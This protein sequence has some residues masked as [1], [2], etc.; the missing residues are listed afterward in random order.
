MT[1]A[2]TIFACNTGKANIDKLVTLHSIGMGLNH[3]FYWSTVN[4][5]RFAGLNFHVFRSFQEYH[6]RFSMNIIQASYDGI[7]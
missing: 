3:M 2:L 4:G 6:E 1:T 7:V 5:E